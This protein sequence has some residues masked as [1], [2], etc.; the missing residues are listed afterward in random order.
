MV[1]TYLIMPYRKYSCQKSGTSGTFR[2]VVVGSMEKEDG[3][4]HE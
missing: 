4:A 2:S 1:D 3:T